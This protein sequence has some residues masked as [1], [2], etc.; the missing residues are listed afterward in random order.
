MKIKLFSFASFRI[1]GYSKLQYC[2]ELSSS[3]LWKCPIINKM[4]NFEYDILNVVWLFWDLNYI[5]N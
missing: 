3:D 1:S 2:S 5:S 4:A